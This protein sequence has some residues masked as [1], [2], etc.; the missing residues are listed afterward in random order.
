MIGQH[1]VRQ[2]SS[3][4]DEDKRTLV[5]RVPPVLEGR[6]DSSWW[7]LLS[8]QA[9][10]D[11]NLATA[12]SSSVAGCEV[13]GSWEGCTVIGTFYLMGPGEL[14]LVSPQQIHL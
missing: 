8:I 7:S 6:G 13:T 12:Q 9:V 10:H 3:A 1:K 11:T 14:I 2:L 4:C 5:L